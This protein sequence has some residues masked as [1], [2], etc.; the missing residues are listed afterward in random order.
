MKANDGC[1]KNKENWQSFNHS[2][3][4]KER[5]HKLLI[6]R[7]R[8]E[9]LVTVVPTDIT[10]MKLILWTTLWGKNEYFIEIDKF[11]EIFELPELTEVEMESLDSPNNLLRKITCDSKPSDK[12]DVWESSPPWQ[13]LKYLTMK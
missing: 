5:R 7:M 2:D 8:E 1:L 11:I 10:R 12:E 4:E 6:S 9:T 3:K 13:F